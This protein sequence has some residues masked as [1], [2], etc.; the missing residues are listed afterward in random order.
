MIKKI[1]TKMQIGGGLA[2]LFKVG[3][4]L[5]AQQRERT[6]CCE[7]AK[8][9]QVPRDAQKGTGKGSLP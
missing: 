2:G 9:V 7:S 1:K 6:C 5:T 8:S 3:L 4:A